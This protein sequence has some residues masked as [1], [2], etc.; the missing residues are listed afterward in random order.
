MYKLIEKIN[1]IAKENKLELYYSL[2]NNKAKEP[3]AV[4]S[5][6]SANELI[7]IDS[8]THTQNILAQI[9][10]YTDSLKSALFWCERM[11]GSLHALR[12][13]SLSAQPAIKESSDEF[14]IIIEMEV[15]L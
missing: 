13:H 2:A 1:K 5:M 3:Y 6:I 8:K 12:P 4:L 10:I 15:L 9:D 7:G 14:R 11:L